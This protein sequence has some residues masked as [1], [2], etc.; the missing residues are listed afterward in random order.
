VSTQEHEFT[1]DGEQVW[2]RSIKERYGI[3]RVKDGGRPE[4]LATCRNKSA[5]GTA[6]C[7]LGEEGE[8][9]DYCVGV[10]DGRD[11]KNQKGEWVGTWLVLPW[12]SKAAARKLRGK[13]R[14]S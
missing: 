1:L 4:L 5:V 10:M 9:L 6:I 3:F 11:H 14:T 2:P 8:F 13:G 12:F 7:K